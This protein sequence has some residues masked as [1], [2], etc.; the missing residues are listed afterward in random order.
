MGR[1]AGNRAVVFDRE[2]YQPGDLVRVL[3]TGATS[4]TMTG[5]PE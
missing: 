5:R 1:T 3:I 2:G 4:A